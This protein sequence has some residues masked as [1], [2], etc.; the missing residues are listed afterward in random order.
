MC[1]RFEIVSDAVAAPAGLVRNLSEYGRKPTSPV[2]S[3]IVTGAFTF[4]STS[5]MPA[6]TPSPAIFAAV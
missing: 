2:T 6:A 4:V 5:T 1:H 3:E